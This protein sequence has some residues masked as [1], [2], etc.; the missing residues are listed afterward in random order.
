MAWLM[1][2]IVRV[3][4][5]TSSVDDITSVVGGL[6]CGRRVGFVSSCC[7]NLTLISL[8]VWVF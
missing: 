5:R 6:D 2:P 4:V 3:F 1:D 7:R 8:F